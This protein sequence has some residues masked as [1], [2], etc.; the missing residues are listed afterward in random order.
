MYITYG[1]YMIL[2][3]PII[4]F[5]IGFAYRTQRISQVG[6][7]GIIFPYV[8]LIVILTG[9][10]PN[11]G[12]GVISDSQRR[13]NAKFSKNI[14]FS[15]III[16]IFERNIPK[17]EFSASLE[18]LDVLKNLD[19]G[20]K[21][22]SISDHSREISIMINLQPVQVYSGTNIYDSLIE[23]ES[24]GEK[25]VEK[26]INAPPIPKSKGS[27]PRP[28][29]RL[30]MTM[31]VESNPP[32]IAKCI[33]S[34]KQQTDFA[35]LRAICLSLTVQPVQAGSAAPALKQDGH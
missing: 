21:Y 2:A 25:Q 16:P 12:Q 32:L 35:E 11:R 22:L 33:G 1:F 28:T 5:L 10:E 26:Y 31:P 4:I 7:F 19:Y 27:R 30:E 34:A 24:V 20:E 17:R 8:V 29:Y 6:I 3:F 9:Y 15:R 18:A 23:R 14:K 13:Y